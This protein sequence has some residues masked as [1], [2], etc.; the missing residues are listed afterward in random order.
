MGTRLVARAV[1]YRFS[2]PTPGPTPKHW[3]GELKRSIC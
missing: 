3:G 2:N 1:D